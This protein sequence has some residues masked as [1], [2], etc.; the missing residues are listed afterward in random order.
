MAGNIKIAAPKERFT[1]VPKDIIFDKKIDVLSLGLYVRLLNLGRTWTMNVHGLAKHLDLSLPKVQKCLAVLE[2]E[3]YVKRTK[4]RGERGRFC[5]WD[6][7]VLSTSTDNPILP[8]S[9]KTDNRKNR[10]SEN[11][12]V[13]IKTINIDKDYKENKDINKKEF[14]TALPDPVE[15]ERQRIAAARLAQQQ[16]R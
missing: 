7:E 12:A 1:R 16:D 8:T 13:Y 2:R 11:G 5:G 4:C 10:Q 9:V 6:Y 3:G 15:R 14:R